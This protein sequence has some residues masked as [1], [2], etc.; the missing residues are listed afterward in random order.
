VIFEAFLSILSAPIR[1]W[2]HSK[3]VLLTLLGREIKW[4][5]QRR[6]GAETSWSEALCQH[7]VLTVVGL[8]WTAALFWLNPLLAGWL[9]PVTVPMA[10][11]IPVS[12]L[13]SRVSL[14]KVLQRWGLLLIPEENAPPEIIR[15]LRSLYQQ[16][17]APAESRGVLRLAS[18]AFASAVHLAFLRGKSARSDKAKEQTMQLREKAVVEGVSKLAPVGN[19]P[20][21]S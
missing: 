11:S 9:L 14:G 21:V 2:F 7:G 20:V 15:N 3:Y 16:A 13:T 4:H 17:C 8:A 10:L 19:C 6:D 1:M 12:V 18:D 5:A